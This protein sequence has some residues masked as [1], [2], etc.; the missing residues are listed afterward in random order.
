MGEVQFMWKKRQQ[1]LGMELREVDTIR[2]SRIRSHK[3]RQEVLED[4]DGEIAEPLLF[5]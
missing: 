2:R 4:L 1:P 5:R 3:Q